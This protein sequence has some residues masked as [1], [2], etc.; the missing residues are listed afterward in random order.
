MIIDIKDVQIGDFVAISK[1]YYTV[2]GF[3]AGQGKNYSF[4]YYDM[5]TLARW[6]NDSKT[7]IKKYYIKYYTCRVIKYSP[8]FLNKNNKEQF[9]KAIEALKQ[10]KVI[11]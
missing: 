2:F 10:L 4:Q 7:I 11:Q 6:L 3:Y 8:E 1:Y 9:E 5:D